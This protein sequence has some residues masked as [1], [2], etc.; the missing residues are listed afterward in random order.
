MKHSIHDNILTVDEFIELYISVGWGEP[1]R[2]QAE[3]SLKNSYAT[4]SVTDGSRVIAMARL[5]GDG[6]MAFFLKD[7]IVLPEYQR[8]GTGRALL[9]HVENYIRSQLK[10][11]WTARFQL[12]SARE[13]EGFYISCGYTQ[14]P[15]KQSGA[16]FTKMIMR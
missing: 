2:E 7:L 3:L 16:G 1:N 13:K 5:L 14:H 4:F 6:G 10:E 9:S 15:N 12:V 11:G 8:L